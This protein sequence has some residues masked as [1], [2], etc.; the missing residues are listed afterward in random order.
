MGP[1]AEEWLPTN[2]SFKSTYFCELI[3][4]RLAGAAFP[5]QAGQRKR[6]VYLHM[7]NTRP[8]NS[9]KSLHCVADN[10]F[11]RIPHSPYSPDIAPSDS[12]L[13][14]TVKQRLQTCKGRSFEELQENVHEILSL[15]GPDELE[16]T[17]RA[18][19]EC[20]RRVIVIGGDHV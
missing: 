9:R 18:W 4:P 19:M 16:A 17:M 14:G 1:L 20:L 11:K 5:G 3:V 13:F 12:Y 2:A 6:G 8:H 10:Q 7:D 15:I